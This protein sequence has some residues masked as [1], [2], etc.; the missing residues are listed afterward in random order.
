MDLTLPGILLIILNLLIWASFASFNLNELGI[1]E[2]KTKSEFSKLKGGFLG[3]FLFMYVI[4]HC[5]SA[6]P[7][8]PL[9][10]RKMLGSNPGLLQLW[11]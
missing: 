11:H 1:K 9:C 10:R 2:K 4:Q 6:A 3:I 8:I 5:S 7:Q